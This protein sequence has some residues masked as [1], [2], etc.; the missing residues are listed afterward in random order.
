MFL[1]VV[2]I[3]HISQLYTLWDPLLYAHWRYLICVSW[4][5]DGYNAAETCRQ[6]FLI[7]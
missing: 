5:E 2:C 3:T 6:E 4:P 7:Y 1:T